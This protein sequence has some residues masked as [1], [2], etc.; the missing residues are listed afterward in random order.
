[1]MQSI[2]ELRRASLSTSAEPWK[3]AVSGILG[4]RTSHEMLGLSIT[5]RVFTLPK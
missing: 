1:M 3:S 4:L 5:F 2:T